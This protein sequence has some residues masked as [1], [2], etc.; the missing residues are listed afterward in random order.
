M[1]LEDYLKANGVWFRLIDKQSTVH[2]A[3]AAAATGLS[4]ERVTKSLVF[5]ADSSPVLAIIPGNCR[6]DISKFKSAV[7]AKD[8]KMVPFADAEKYSGYPPGAT[9]PIFHKNIEKTVIDV[10]VMRHETV[11]GGGGSNTT[12]IELKPEDIQRLNNAMI[13]DIAEV[14]K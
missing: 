9:P 1:S 3:D 4:L 8:L 13:A 2:T 11:F 10:R 7:G 12:L 6:V 5:I 14:N